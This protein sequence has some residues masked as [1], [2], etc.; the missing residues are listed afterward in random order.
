MT[1]PVGLRAD[2]ESLET[3][4]VI[5]FIAASSLWAGVKKNAVDLEIN[6]VKSYASSRCVTLARFMCEDSRHHQPQHHGRCSFDNRRDRSSRPPGRE[7]TRESWVEGRRHWL[8]KSKAPYN[9]QSWPLLRGRD[10]KGASRGQVR[11]PIRSILQTGWYL[12]G[13]KDHRWLF[14][15]SV[16][17]NLLVGKIFNT[18]KVPQTD[19]QTNVTPTLK[20]LELSISKP[21]VPSHDYP[22]HPIPI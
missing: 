12:W 16:H 2:R 18:S 21:L 3:Q 5:F 6:L 1:A 11:T 15:V 4:L 10:L 19:S 14:I 8:C 9:P 22:L 20:A 17:I 13:V 7:S